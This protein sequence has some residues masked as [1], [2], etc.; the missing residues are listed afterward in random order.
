MSRLCLSVTLESATVYEANYRPI[1]IPLTE[2]QIER[3]ERIKERLSKKAAGVRVTR[4]ETLRVALERGFDVL[5][6]ELAEEE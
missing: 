2:A 5:E 3:A 1:P 4:T 6:S